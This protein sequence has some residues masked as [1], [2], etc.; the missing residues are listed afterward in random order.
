[1]A[2]KKLPHKVGDWIWV[3]GSVTRI[4]EEDGQIKD[5][6]VQLSNGT[7]NTL[8]YSPDSIRVYDEETV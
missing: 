8:T 7:K 4:G 5:I 1:M 3:R 6:T 2:R